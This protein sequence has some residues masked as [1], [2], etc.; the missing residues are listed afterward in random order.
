MTNSKYE[1]FWTTNPLRHPGLSIPQQ[2][3]PSKATSKDIL[4]F[5]ISQPAKLFREEQIFWGTDP[6]GAPDIKE[7]FEIHT[8]PWLSRR[9]SHRLSRRLGGRLSGRLRFRAA[10]YFVSVLL[11]LPTGEPIRASFS[12]GRAGFSSFD[13]LGS[14]LFHTGIACK[15]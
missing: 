3:I 4:I 13:A 6:L 10:A 5:Q 15:K 11:S 12:T 7:L 2:H 1:L 8:W 9:L 14:F